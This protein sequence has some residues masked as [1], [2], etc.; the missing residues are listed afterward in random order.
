[1]TTCVKLGSREVL[2]HL[3]FFFTHISVK[4]ISILNCYF[5]NDIIYIDTYIKNKRK[6]MTYMQIKYYIRVYM[7]KPNL[8]GYLFKY[9][10]GEPKF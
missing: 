5:F 3:E 7:Q 10:K 8:E 2:N 1:M 6:R 9:P 4:S